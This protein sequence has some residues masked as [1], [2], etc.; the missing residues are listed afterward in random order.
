MQGLQELPIV[1]AISMFSH[2][3]AT[4]CIKICEAL[5]LRRGVENTTDRSFTESTFLEKRFRARK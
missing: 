2:K 4:E 3:L 5:D 1:L